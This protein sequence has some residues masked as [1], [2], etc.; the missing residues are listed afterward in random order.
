MGLTSKSP[1]RT[2]GAIVYS[3]SPN[4]GESRITRGG[5]IVYTCY[6]GGA[7][8]PGSGFFYPVA[9]NGD[10]VKLWSGAGR[11]NSV[12]TFSPQLLQ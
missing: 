4:T 9:Q 12:I 3:G 11:L 2:V 1:L 5:E 7:L 6:S 8:N 10:Q